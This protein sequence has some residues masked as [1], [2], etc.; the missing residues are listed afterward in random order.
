VSALDRLV[1]RMLEFE[2]EDRSAY[3]VLCLAI[4]GENTPEVLDS[5]R[6]AADRKIC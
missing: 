4:L 2:P 1:S 3:L 5:V 6:E